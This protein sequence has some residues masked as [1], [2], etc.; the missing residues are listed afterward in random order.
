MLES[1]RE[2]GI[3]C[4]DEGAIV[5]DV[6][7]VSVIDVHQIEF[8]FFMQ[9]IGQIGDVDLILVGNTEHDIGRND[10]RHLCCPFVVVLLSIVKLTIQLILR[11]ITKIK[12]N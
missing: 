4:L 3:V 9:E 1:N 10:F 5:V 8:L 11:Y 12:Q 2:V 7:P 6:W